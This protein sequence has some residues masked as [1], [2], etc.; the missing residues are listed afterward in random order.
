MENTNEK[1]YIVD[2]EVDTS[3]SS[4]YKFYDDYNSYSGCS[5]RNIIQRTKTRTV[6][7]R[8]GRYSYN[9]EESYIEKLPFYNICEEINGELFDLITGDKIV[10]LPPEKRQYGRLTYDFL[11][12]SSKKI[13]TKEKLGI[14]LRKLTDADVGR[15]VQTMQ[16]LKIDIHNKCLENNKVKKLNESEVDKFK[17]RY[18]RK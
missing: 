16:R 9:C 17:K 3:S 5:F 11:C 13:I 10:Y 2:L 14:E 1:Y 8:N 15:Y 7:K 12:C 6:V 4:D 18:G